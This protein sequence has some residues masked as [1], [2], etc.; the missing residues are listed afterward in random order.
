MF[1]KLFIISI[2]IGLSL[3]IK[4]NVEIE[5]TI[6]FDCL[7]YTQCV[8]DGNKLVWGTVS[9]QCISNTTEPSGIIF[10]PLD[11][12]NVNVG[13]HFV[14]AQLISKNIVI[15]GDPGAPST[16]FVIL[17]IKITND[18]TS[19]IITKDL[20]IE[21]EI[22]ETDN[23][24]PCKY[25]STIPCADRH[26]LIIPN[27]FVFDIGSNKYQLDFINNGI[28]ENILDETCRKEFPDEYKP[29]NIRIFCINCCEFEYYG[30]REIR[31]YC[32]WRFRIFY[33]N[34]IFPNN[35]ATNANFTFIK[36]TNSL[37]T[38]TPSQL[39]NK[40]FIINTEIKPLNEATNYNE[41]IWS[42]HKIMPGRYILRI[43]TEEIACQSKIK[44]WIYVGPMR[45]PPNECPPY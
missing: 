25:P 42:P 9:D 17:K 20:N 24:E 33:N 3:S 10:N 6:I 28:I 35:Y 7:P 44:I 34:N 38:Y 15:N 8:Q 1:L 37:E 18:E 39:T 31:M 41:Y 32:P 11:T 29:L 13:S 19:D 40:I 22:E 5:N 26:I 16:F 36:T 2:F 30:L 4:F 43:E 27:D 21:F 45:Q 14:L 12:F 23:S